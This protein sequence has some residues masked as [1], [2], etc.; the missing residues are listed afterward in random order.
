[1][2][3]RNFHPAM[4]CTRMTIHSLAS[5]V[6]CSCDPKYYNLL[7]IV[8]VFLSFHIFTSEGFKSFLTSLPFTFLAIS[9]AHPRAKL[10]QW[11]IVNNDDSW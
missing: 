7:L 6:S 8:F 10:T 11:F 9:S 2:R 4:T 1:M 5:G 3:S